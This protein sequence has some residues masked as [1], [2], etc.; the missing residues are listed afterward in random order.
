MMQVESDVLLGPHTDS[1]AL[2]LEHELEG[3][4]GEEELGKWSKVVVEEVGRKTQISEVGPGVELR[5]Q[6]LY[7]WA[8]GED[9]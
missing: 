6:V 5:T 7:D 1:L 9:Q 4:A 8:G 2:D 3:M